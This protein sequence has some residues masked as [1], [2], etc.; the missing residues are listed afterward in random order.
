[1]SWQPE[2]D[3]LREREALAR[4]MGG[5]DKVERQRDAGATAMRP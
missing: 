2:I 4:R 1:M 3:A 5:A